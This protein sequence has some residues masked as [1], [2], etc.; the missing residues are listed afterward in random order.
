LYEAFIEATGVRMSQKQF[1]TEMSRRGFESKRITK[2]AYKAKIGRHGLRL[3][4]DRAKE[5]AGAKLQAALNRNRL[6]RQGEKNNA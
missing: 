4:E 3:V 1:G 6:N 2:G 5:V